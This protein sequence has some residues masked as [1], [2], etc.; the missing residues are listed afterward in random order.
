MSE[1][2]LDVCCGSRMFWFDRKDK[3]AV[4]C[5]N[6]QETHVLKDKSSKGGSRALIIEPDYV[7]DFT[8]LPF[9]DECFSLVVFDPPHLVR[10]G[11]SGWLAKKYGKLGVNWEEDIRQGF[12]ECFR[13]LKPEGTLIFKWNEHEIAVSKILSLTT[14]KPLLGNRGGRTA[15]THWMV[16]QKRP[17]PYPAPYPSIHN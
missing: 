15:K 17:V 14:E 8:A 1:G 6:R 16:F 9:I 2:V 7:C 13:V 3:R 4:Y 10:N 5:D 11:R 12:A